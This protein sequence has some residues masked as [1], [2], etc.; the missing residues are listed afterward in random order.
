MGFADGNSPFFVFQWL[1]DWGVFTTWSITDEE[2]EAR[3]TQ[4]TG[5]V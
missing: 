1:F 5:P 2:I 3:E 4:L